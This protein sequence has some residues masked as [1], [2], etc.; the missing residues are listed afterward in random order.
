MF[1]EAILCSRLPKL[2]DSVSGCSWICMSGAW[3][4]RISCKTAS[5]K[6]SG[7]LARIA[8]GHVPKHLTDLPKEIFTLIERAK[9]SA[10]FTTR[11]IHIDGF[12]IN[13]VSYSHCLHVLA[14]QLTRSVTKH[15]AFA[16]GEFHFRSA[17]KRA[18]LQGSKV[19]PSSISN[20]TSPA[21]HGIESATQP[22]ALLSANV[23]LDPSP[24][25][26][27]TT[28]RHP[29]SRIRMRMV[30]KVVQLSSRGSERE[31]T[32]VKTQVTD[33]ESTEQKTLTHDHEYV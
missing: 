20:S 3:R 10:A 1:T 30:P 29:P 8:P 14:P 28:S 4:T 17:F 5:K 32:R 11:E 31:K 25:M 2:L 26:K 33:H 16:C 13:N 6:T 12:A 18:T 24:V 9:Q 22:S 19:L 23:S 15:E 27:V 21:G 7:V